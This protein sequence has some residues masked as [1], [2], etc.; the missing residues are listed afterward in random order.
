ME[1][2]R[3]IVK[4]WGEDE[5]VEMERIVECS[6]LYGADPSEVV[7]VP[8]E[9][10][11]ARIVRGDFVATLSL[12]PLSGRPRI[13]RVSEGVAISLPY[14]FAMRTIRSTNWLFFL[15]SSPRL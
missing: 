8:L 15:T 6:R 3:Q 5:G 14:S 1:S 12:Y 4:F 11:W 7:K 9:K 10:I 13:S 2:V